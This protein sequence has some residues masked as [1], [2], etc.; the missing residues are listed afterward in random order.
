[1][2]LI[3]SLLLY[4]TAFP[5]ELANGTSIRLVFAG[6]ELHDDSKTLMACNITNHSNVHAVINTRQSQQSQPSRQQHQSQE[7]SPEL[8]LS[9]L[10]VPLLVA[11]ITFIWITFFLNMEHFNNKA[12]VFLLAV[13][14]V[15]MVTLV[16]T[17]GR[18]NVS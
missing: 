10:F 1:M 7:E 8:D 5:Q 3:L 2:T 4:R 9:K 6:R 12:V 18:V 17:S 11:F 13:S 14:V 15:I 16:G